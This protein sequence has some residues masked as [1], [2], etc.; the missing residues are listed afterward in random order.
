MNTEDVVRQ[1]EV[2]SSLS[3]IFPDVYRWRHESVVMLLW[4]VQQ[5]L[6]VKP[7]GRPEH[8]NRECV[9]QCVPNNI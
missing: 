3:Q 4:Y 1:L 8:N 9:L 7:D 6:T 2:V 5:T